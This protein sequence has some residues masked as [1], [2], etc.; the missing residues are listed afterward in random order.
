MVWWC[1]DGERE[2][3]GVL[4]V[5]WLCPK[6]CWQE[7]Y[8]STLDTVACLVACMLV[9][10]DYSYTLFVCLFV[11]LD[12]TRTS[13]RTLE[14]FGCRNSIALWYAWLLGCLVAGI[15]SH[16]GCCYGALLIITLWRLLSHFK[17]RGK[18]SEN[19]LSSHGEVFELSSVWSSRAISSRTMWVI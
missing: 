18:Q 3:I 10:G 17:W 6:D 2:G 15:L 16:C 12:K 14:M 19:G 4:I 1:G 13:I 11:C 9:Y 7:T 5:Y 8:K